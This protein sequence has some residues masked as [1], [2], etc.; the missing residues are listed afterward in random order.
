MPN[1]NQGSAEGNA[2][3]ATYAEFFLRT[4]A[5]GIERLTFQ[6]YTDCP[7][8]RDEYMGG[9]RSV[10]D[11]SRVM[12]LPG[13]LHQ[14]DPAHPFLVTVASV[15]S[16]PPYSD[17]DFQAAL[18][19]AEALFATSNN[20]QR[21][22]ADSSSPPDMRQGFPDGH[23]TCE[24]TR[25][26]GWCLGPWNMFEDQAVAACLEWNKY[27]IPPLSEE[28]VR[29][30]VANIAK[31]EANKRQGG[32]SQQQQGHGDGSPR[33]SDQAALIDE[34][35][36]LDPISYDRR[37]EKA[38]EQLGIR[39]TALDEAVKQRRAKL[40]DEAE[41]QPLFAHWD[42]KP[43]PEP[44]DGD[45]LILALVRRIRCHV[46][47]SIE[48]ALTVALWII[49]T[50]V[51]A[52]AAIH[53]PILIV[54]SPE[55]ECGKTTLL[56]LI[57]FLVRRALSSVGISSAALYRAIEK[58]GPTVVIDEA[59]VAFVE[60]DELR[61]AV[62]SG[63]TRGQGVLR[64]EGD[65]HEPRLFATFC[66]KAIG[67]KGKKVPDTTASRAI[68]IELKRKLAHEEVTDFRHID[69]S[70]LQELRQK[71]LRW[72]VDN[73][74]ELQNPQPTLPHGFSNRVAANWLL[75]LAIADTA[76]GEWPDKAREAAA[77]IAKLKAAL[78]ASIGIQL[79]SDTRI[80]FGDKDCLFSATLVGILTGDPE[81]PWGEYNRGKPFTQK[82]LAN[83]LRDY[84]I[85]TVWI[86]GKSAKGYKRAAFEDV[87]TRYLP[88]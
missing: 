84:Q 29:S 76:G 40:A 46:V 73:V 5:P 75:L 23:R 9:D 51:H 24:L 13:F 19:E 49:F 79:L 53:S 10:C 43:W 87:W 17:L 59:D 26:A 39:V 54:T 55:A 44:V 30:T 12:R 45:A 36:R 32:N 70:G 78:A 8:K 77:A 42:V 21:D 18:A 7:N 85:E 50:W 52:A 3:N 33:D 65:E 34:L 22:Q 63:W 66:P 1:I 80:A 58:W 82:Q 2:T 83:R 48:A 72:A 41:E 57:G 47:M 69:D 56:G 4:L 62:N 67:L 71:L 81:G 38:A 11:L 25:R 61:A 31:A 68:A 74:A 16:G 15:E 14:K 86:G 27:N 6:T 88:E 37:R 60:N 28:K 20:K 64:C 35:A